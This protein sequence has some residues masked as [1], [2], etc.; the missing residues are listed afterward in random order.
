[1]NKNELA[2]EERTIFIVLAIIIMIAIGVLVTWYFTKDKN[3]VEDKDTKTKTVDKQKKKDIGQDTSKYTFVPS[4][5]EELLAVNNKEEVV[6]VNKIED[7]YINFN[8]NDNYLYLINEK[9]NFASFSLT[10]PVPFFL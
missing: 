1:M 10:P 9:I 8:E 3:E 7:Q 2:K 5:K 6:E 4:K